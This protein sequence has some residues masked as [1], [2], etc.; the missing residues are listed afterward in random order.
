[1]NKHFKIAATSGRGNLM[2]RDDLYFGDR[3]DLDLFYDGDEGIDFKSEEISLPDM[4]T[5]INVRLQQQPG[6]TREQLLEQF[7]QQQMQPGL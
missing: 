6:K 2:S 5:S 3:N 4:T 1:M 7:M